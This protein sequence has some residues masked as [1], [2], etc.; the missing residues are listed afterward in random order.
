MEGSMLHRHPGYRRAGLTT[1]VAL[2]VALALGMH[3]AVAAA[4]AGD[5]VNGFGTTETGRT[6]DFTV[7]GSA[8]GANPTGH[9]SLTGPPGGYTWE[10]TPR[11]MNVAGDRATLGFFIDSGSSGGGSDISG[12]GVLLW[13]HY[14]S[15]AGRAYYKVI[16]RDA[17]ITCPDPRP[18]RDPSL[19][20]IG[21][22]GDIFVVDDQPPILLGSDSVSGSAGACLF[23]YM[24]QACSDSI[25]I[26]LNVA[27]TEL[28]ENPTGVVYVDYDGPS[29]SSISHRQAAV[30][31]L[32]VS[33]Q[34]AIIGVTG[35]RVDGEQRNRQFAGFIQVVDGGGPDTGADKFDFALPEEPSDGPPMS[36][37]S[38][39]SSFPGP[40]G[41]ISLAAFTNGKGN[42]VVTDT[43]P[44]PSSKDQC[45]N[46][47]WRNFPGF[48]NQGDCVSFVATGGKN[49]PAGTTKP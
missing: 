43:R 33:D 36:G 48:K 40:L 42:V 34:V 3:A 37:P 38:D 28:G 39:C 47:G 24:E 45:K 26:S 15:G 29:P 49:A 30:T 27:S 12:Q 35:S 31:C 8:T 18:G 21:F 5:V 10:A 41:G 17:P 7:E 44:L 1:T 25:E 11:C 46:R 20:S 22:F 4:Q 32:S 23:R 6:F 14:Q 19:S 16:G 9:F 2:T 13:V